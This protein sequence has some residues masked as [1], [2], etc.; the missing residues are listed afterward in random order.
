MGFLDFTARAR[1]FVQVTMV[2]RCE[3]RRG[4]G[5]Q[6]YDPVTQTYTPSPGALVWSGP[7]RVRSAGTVGGGGPEVGEQI[8]TLRAYRA[9]LPLDALGIDPDDR[10][11]VTESADAQLLTVPLRVVDPQAGTDAK[12]RRVLLEADLG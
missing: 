2:D 11:T 6:V 7:C 3:I 5:Q 8:I 9:T 4:G 12:F 10:F 1:E